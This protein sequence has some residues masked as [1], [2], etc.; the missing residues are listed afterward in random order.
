MA[1]ETKKIQ[2]LISRGSPITGEIIRK[3]SVMDF[4]LFWADRFIQDGTA[5]EVVDGGQK[6]ASK[7]ADPTPKKGKKK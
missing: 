7:A 6:E 3:D 5:V 4:P 1:Q 2:F